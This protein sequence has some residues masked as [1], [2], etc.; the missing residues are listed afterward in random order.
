M[1]P[2]LSATGRPQRRSATTALLVFG[3]ALVASNAQST[4]RVAGPDDYLQVVRFLQAGD[5]LQLRSGT[6]VHGLDVHRLMGRSDAE[7]VIRGTSGARRSVFLARPGRNTISI[8]DAAFVTIADLDLVG[9]PGVHVDAVKAEGT[10]RFAHHITL[11]GLVIRGYDS[12]QQNVAISTKCPAWGW[13]IRGNAIVGGGTGLYLGNSDGGA[14]FVGGLIERNVVVGTTGYAMQIKHQ[15]ERAQLPGLPAAAQNTIIRDN[16]FA[17]D[18]R[19]SAGALARPNVLLGHWPPAGAGADDR[20]L[21]YGNIFLDNPHEA[22]LQAEGNVA[23][24]N[25]VFINRWGDGVTI[26][27]H[28]GVP[29][30]VD[31]FHNTIIAKG[32]GL[33]IRDGDPRFEQ[34][35][36]GNAIFAAGVT[37][38]VLPGAN[39][40]GHFGDERRYLRRP[41]GGLE[42]LDLAPLPGTLADARFESR[43]RDALPDATRDFDRVRRIGGVAGA[44]AGAGAAHRTRW[45]ELVAVLQRLNASP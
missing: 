1:T 20:Y 36:A 33:S 8:V 22:L 6:Y 43:G 15:H 21:V 5:T 3:L 32:A 24:Y 27:A 31:V 23:L 19:S 29:R 42:M 40:V 9:G 38:A 39:V 26:H 2:S 14:P 44:Y 11:V 28:K 7:I 4:T 34:R 16:A 10:A 41:E 37:G 35:A 45:R 13:V 17:K 30:D 25:N 12:E 18:A